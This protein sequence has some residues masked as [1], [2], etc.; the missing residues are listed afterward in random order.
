M[1]ERTARSLIDANFRSSEV[2]TVRAVEVGRGKLEALFRSIHVPIMVT[3]DLEVRIPGGFTEIGDG[4][5]AF[6]TSIPAAWLRRLFLDKGTD[7]FSANVRGYLGSI[8]SERNI[9][10]NIKRTAREEPRRFWAYNNGLTALVDDYTVSRRGRSGKLRL[11]GMSIVNGAQ[12]TGALGAVPVEDEAALASARVLA[13]FVKCTDRDVINQIIRFNNSQNVV[14]PFDFRSGDQVQRRLVTEFQDIPEA[15]YRGF[16]RG[17]ERDQIE[18]PANLVP[19]STAAQ[20]L[21]AFHGDPTT[22]YNEKGKISEDSVYP[23]YFND[24]T[25][26]RHLLFCYSLYRALED[27][28]RSVGGI[29]PTARTTIQGA[30]SGF[31]A[32]RGSLFLG[33]YAVARS[34]ESILNSRV[35]DPFTLEFT[36]NVGPR[37]AASL[38][39][40]VVSATLPFVQQLEPALERNLKD[41]ETIEP[42]VRNF[43]ALVEATKDAN[44]EPFRR[45]A[46]EVTCR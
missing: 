2:A 29:P 21:V 8:G 9:N 35:P 10:H 24:A 13:R 27:A 43:A 40:P 33:V 12:T 19:S 22:A 1:V 37:E 23:N 18:R 30:Q 28:K 20:A 46:G 5:E 15:D 3:D 44:P 31:F 16:R 45:L 14:E 41:R 4:W 38:W 39:L 26:A 32:K 42:A 11:K 7:L 25:T 36:R 34:L 17:G 6:C